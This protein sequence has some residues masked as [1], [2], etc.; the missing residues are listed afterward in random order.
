MA[1]KRPDAGAGSRAFVNEDAGDPI[2]GFEG[3]TTSSGLDDFHIMGVKINMANGD[4][5]D[6]PIPSL[7]DTRAFG[8]GRAGDLC[9]TG[10]CSWREVNPVT[11]TNTPPMIATSRDLD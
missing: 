8:A 6:E 2:W 9:A 7:A 11:G 10:E 3:P 5:N 1:V 4:F